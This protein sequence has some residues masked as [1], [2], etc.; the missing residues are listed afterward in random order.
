MAASYTHAETE[1][2]IHGGNYNPPPITFTMDLQVGKNLICYFT[3]DFAVPTGLKVDGVDAVFL[4]S[5]ASNYVHWFVADVASAGGNV[6]E[7]A[8]PAYWKTTFFAAGLVT[9]ADLATVSDTATMAF[10]YY[11]GTQETTDD[12]IVPAN[13]IGFAVGY[14]STASVSPVSPQ[15]INGSPVGAW[16]SEGKWE[17]YATFGPG[18]IRPR[19]QSPNYQGTLIHAIAF[20][21]SAGAPASLIL[22]RPPGIMLPFL[23]R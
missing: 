20:G 17:F 19:I 12:L 3:Q 9:G 7:L 10:G 23:M 11:E 22:P 21:P 18:T 15:F 2:P 4:T 6:V 1:Q 8:Q 5:G 13:G 16:L 14:Q